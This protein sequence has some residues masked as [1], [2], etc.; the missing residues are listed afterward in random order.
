MQN[1]SAK[2]FIKGDSETTFFSSRGLS[3]REEKK[4]RAKTWLYIFF[5]STELLRKKVYK[6]INK[7][8]FPIQGFPYW[9]SR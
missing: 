8:K 7:F 2:H 6:Y 3:E 5:P 9:S 1:Q 4:A